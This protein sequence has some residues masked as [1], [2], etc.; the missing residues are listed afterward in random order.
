[1]KIKLEEYSRS[2]GPDHQPALAE[3]DVVMLA[4]YLLGSLLDLGHEEC[5]SESL[6]EY[7]SDPDAAL[8]EAVKESLASDTHT[9]L[10]FFTNATLVEQVKTIADQD[11]VMPHKSTYFYPKILTGLIMNK[12]VV[13][14][15]IE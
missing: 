7:Y 3:L 11:L 1:M 15:T 4:D 8:D 13:D 2:L 12:M 9:P 14:E 5:E 10:L 6:I